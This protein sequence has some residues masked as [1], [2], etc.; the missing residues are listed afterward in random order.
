MLIRV[1]KQ[2]KGA[3]DGFAVRDYLVGEILDFTDAPARAKELG[4][5]FLREGWAELVAE[6]PPPAAPRVRRLPLLEEYVAAG[7]MAENYELMLT[8]Q[9]AEASAAGEVVEVREKSP[10]EI[11]EEAVARAASFD[12]QPEI[13]ASP[14]VAPP[15]AAA[16]P[17]APATPA[18]RKGK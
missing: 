10:A 6:P 4:A 8:S 3:E 1:T 18:K 2:T 17:P 9:R 15:A 12:R 5:V 13:A 7:Y 16:P 14:E 11:A